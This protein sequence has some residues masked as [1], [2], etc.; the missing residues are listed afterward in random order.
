MS[1]QQVNN[2]NEKK[3]VKEETKAPNTD[4]LEKKPDANAEA[5]NTG[6]RENCSVAGPIKTCA[7][8]KSATYCSRECQRQHWKKHK[9][10]CKNKTDEVNQH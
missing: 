5:I 4:P 6:I 2:S 1:I 10:D 7:S 8:C 9:Y 3:D